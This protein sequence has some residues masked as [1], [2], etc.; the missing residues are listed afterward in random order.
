MI[1]LSQYP[2]PDVIEPLN[3]EGA[4]ST[5]V[6]KFKELWATIRADNPSLPE[7]DVHMLETDPAMILLQV[8]A[9]IDLGLRA[10]INDAA[11]AN[12][13]AFAK[14]ADLDHLAFFYDVIRLEAETDD[15]LRD[16]TVLE[17]K[18][19]SPGGSEWWYEAAARRADVRIRNVKAYREEFWPIIHIAVLSRENGGIPD[20]A[21]L[22]AVREMVTSN[23][24]RTLN[25][26]VIVEAAVQFGTNIEADIWLLPSAPT[27]DLRSLEQALRDAWNKESNIGF[28]LVPSWIEAK[29]H[30]GSVQRVKVLTPT[31]PV[32]AMPGTAIA[33]GNIQLN[34]KGRDF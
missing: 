14:G 12:L 8:S 26:T 21:M 19:R 4:L 34:Y 15:A 1:N 13:L 7:Y 17:I 27:T 3:Y 18:A 23:R 32:V 9:Y 31:A 5:H 20:E 28:D 11:K 24:V 2:A 22:S 30:Q 10:R 33:L 25:D 6:A 16:R 29:L